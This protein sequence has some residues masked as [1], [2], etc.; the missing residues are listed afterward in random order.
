M[1]DTIQS[2]LSVAA[3]SMPSGKTRALLQFNKIT[4]AFVAMLSY[5]DPDTL[6]NEYYTYAEAEL[7][8]ENDMVVGDYPNFQI[9]PAL[10]S[11]PRFTE[12]DMDK[13]VQVKITKRYPVVKQLN[14]VSNVLDSITNA[15]Q[16][17]LP[18]PDE[19]L[20]ESMHQLNEMRAYINEVKQAN[21]LRKEFYASN[22]DF[23]F[24]SK[25]QAASEYERQLEGG[26]H[27]AYGAREVTGGSVF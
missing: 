12:E 27:E 6:N 3:M 26:L 16:K 8:F 10:A 24:I 4:G 14:I 23:E 17:L 18:E 15:V 22:P 13:M 25:E 1:S 11:K 20:S 7:D 19:N 21:A 2:S 9:Q 5:V